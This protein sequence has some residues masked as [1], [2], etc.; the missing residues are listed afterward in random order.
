MVRKSRHPVFFSI[1]S[2]VIGCILQIQGKSLSSGGGG[3]SDSPSEAGA[4]VAATAHS[5]EHY[6][7][8]FDI[9]VSMEV[10][11]IV[12]T[13]APITD[14]KEQ[15]ADEFCDVVDEADEAGDGAAG[16]GESMFDDGNEYEDES[17]DLSDHDEDD[18]EAADEPESRRNG[19]Q[20]IKVKDHRESNDVE[21]K[22][23]KRDLSD[24][25]DP[26]VIPFKTW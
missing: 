25:K 21:S 20:V 17:C 7:P 6:D 22:S 4:G 11:N 3:A 24:G 2:V 23:K 15:E 10:R 1:I 14:L 26:I 16:G 19:T 9:R 5:H 8:K 12:T 13:P 18:D